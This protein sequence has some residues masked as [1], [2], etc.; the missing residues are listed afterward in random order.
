MRTPYV[1]LKPSRRESGK[2]PPKRVKAPYAK[3]GRD[4]SIQSTTRHEEPCGKPGGPPSK[5]KYELVTDSEEVLSSK[6]EK[7]PGRG[8]KKNLKPCV[9]KQLE[10]VKARQRTFCRTVRRVMAVSEVKYLRYGAEGKPSL[11]RALSLLL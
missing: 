8:V 9:Y 3:G 10:S 11:N 1:I 6:G 2:A 5:P 4:R 7:N